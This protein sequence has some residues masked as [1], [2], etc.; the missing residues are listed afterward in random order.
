MCVTQ[1]HFVYTGVFAL[2]VVSLFILFIGYVTWS[3]INRQA[4]SRIER[5]MPEA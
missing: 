4:V 2:A 5:G 3:P 1:K